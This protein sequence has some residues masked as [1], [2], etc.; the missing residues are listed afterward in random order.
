MAC[1]KL[2]FFAAHRFT[3]NF[4]TAAYRDQ[5]IWAQTK[6]KIV[7]MFGPDLVE[8]NL[9]RALESHENFRCGDRKLLAG[10]NIERHIRPTPCVDVQSYGGICLDRRIG[11]NT[12]FVAITA[13][14]TANDISRVKRPNG[15]KQSKFFVPQ[16]FSVAAHWSFHREQR[17]YLEQV[18]LYDVPNCADFF[19][20][21][22]SSLNTKTL[23]HGDLHIG[24][25]VIVPDRFEER[26][27]KP[28]IDQ[29]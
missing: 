25:V 11:S 22:A 4:H 12:V 14:L 2:D 19:I 17:Q 1:D 13:K 29:I 6:T 20:K 9:R 8:D 5:N 21:P 3:G 18:V 27:R 24:N 28:K 7:R 15:F 16:R 26:I 10:P 23:G